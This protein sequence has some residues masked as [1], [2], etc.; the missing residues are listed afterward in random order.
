MATM[1]PNTLN[2]TDDTAETRKAKIAERAKTEE[3]K[4]TEEE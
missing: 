1:G 3:T 4:K 2:G